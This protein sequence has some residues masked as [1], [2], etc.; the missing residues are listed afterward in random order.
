MS[1]VFIFDVLHEVFDRE[2][3]LVGELRRA[4]DE[5]EAFRAENRRLE[6]C[7]P[8]EAKENYKR[9]Y[10]AGLSKSL[11]MTWEQIKEEIKRVQTSGEV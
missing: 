5:L 7:A 10:L 6:T 2:I 8:S 4:L 3:A 11:E 9:G 1:K